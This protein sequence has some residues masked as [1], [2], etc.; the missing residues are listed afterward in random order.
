MRTQPNFHPLPQDSNADD[1]REPWVG[2]AALERTAARL[3]R[4]GAAFRHEA[5]A[6][7]LAERVLAASSPSNR[8]AD[9]RPAV[10]A[11]IGWPRFAAAVAA[12]AVVGGA[13]FLSLDFLPSGGDR[14][15]PA[16]V[17]PVVFRAELNPAGLSENLVIG[18]YDGNAALDAVDLTGGD[19]VSSVVVTRAH[20]ALALESEL[21]GLLN[22]GG[23]R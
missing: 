15:Q 20:D 22:L 2:D 10:V 17:E 6:R 1:A 18:L 4:M 19:V 12:A 13:V 11:R 5:E 9:A 21:Q 3:D 8:A 7:G 16:G 23:G 14:G